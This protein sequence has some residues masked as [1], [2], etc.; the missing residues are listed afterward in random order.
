LCVPSRSYWCHI[1]HILWQQSITLIYPS[2]CD[3][4]SARGQTNADRQHLPTKAPTQP[5]VKPKEGGSGYRRGHC[6]DLDCDHDANNLT[7]TNV[8]FSVTRP[9]TRIACL[10][11]DHLTLER[12]GKAWESREVII[13]KD[14]LPSVIAID[15]PLLPLCADRHIRRHVEPFSFAPLFTILADP[16]SV[17]MRSDWS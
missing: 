16:A 3:R 11:G 13:P 9:T 14:F 8:G 5:S 1:Y 17:I 2:A 4:P 12:V 7:E 6:G 15:G 10:E